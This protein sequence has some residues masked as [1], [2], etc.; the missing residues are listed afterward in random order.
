MEQLPSLLLLLLP[1]LLLLVRLQRLV[2]AG[3]RQR[4]QTLAAA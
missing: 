1:L 3:S 4:T 2:P